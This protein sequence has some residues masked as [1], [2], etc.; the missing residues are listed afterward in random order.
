M[1][2]GLGP[3]E[4]KCLEVLRADDDLDS[5]TIAARAVGR[6]I[7]TDSE[8]TSYRRALRA[9]ARKKLVVDLGRTRRYGRRAWATPEGALEYLNE[10]R[11]LR[12]AVEPD[13]IARVRAA[14]EHQKATQG[15]ESA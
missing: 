15:K 13:V 10:M 3:V 11:A 8:A 12:W 14:V 9:L 1:S 7:I 4:R 6:S 5:I 2:K